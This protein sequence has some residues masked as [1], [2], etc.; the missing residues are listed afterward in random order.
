MVEEN[1]VEE[2]VGEEGAPGAL[3]DQ[4]QSVG[5]TVACFDHVIV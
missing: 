4:M 3:W 2:G 5:G 1:R